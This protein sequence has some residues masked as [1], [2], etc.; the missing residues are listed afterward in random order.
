MSK[1]LLMPKE[2]SITQRDIMDAKH[3]VCDK[4]G[5]D[6]FVN[7]VKVKRISPLLLGS[8]TEELMPIEYLVCEKCNDLSPM[9]KDNEMLKKIL[10]YK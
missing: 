10:N 8:I 9:D 3:V 6:T 5:H 2:V 1:E 7:R 4:C